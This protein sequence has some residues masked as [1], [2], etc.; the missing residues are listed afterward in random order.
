MLRDSKRNL[1]GESPGREQAGKQVGEEALLT[2]H[3]LS[4]HIPVC[5][6]YQTLRGFLSQVKRQ[7]LDTAAPEEGE[8]E[9]TQGATVSFCAFIHKKLFCV[10]T[11]V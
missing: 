4:L 6:P 7:E 3:L 2:K 10:N 9:E 11:L 1:A 8:G 5:C